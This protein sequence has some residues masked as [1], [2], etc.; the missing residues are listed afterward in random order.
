M[1]PVH[2]HCMCH[3]VPLMDGQVDMGEMHDQVEEGG[4]SYIRRM[5]SSDRMN[6]LGRTGIK[7]VMEGGSWTKYARGYRRDVMESRFDNRTLMELNL[8]PS[9]DEFISFISLFAKREEKPYTKGKGREERFYADNKKPIYPPNDGAIGN[10]TKVI[11]KK[12]TILTRY[13]MPAGA[14]TSPEGITLQQRSMSRTSNFREYHKYEVLIAI[15]NVDKAEIAPWF[16]QEGHGIQYKMP[17]SIESLI[18]DKK[19]K[20]VN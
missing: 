3:L 6:L 7:G 1:L 10:S 5:K 12:G 9:T 20:E 8:V 15:E 4:R 13:G 2:P 14:Y 11:L 17:S 19:L 16:D 18:N